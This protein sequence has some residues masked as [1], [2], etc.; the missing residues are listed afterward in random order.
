MECLLHV[1]ECIHSQPSIYVSGNIIVPLVQVS[2]FWN[3]LRYSFKH[4]H[5]QNHTIKSVKP[6]IELQTK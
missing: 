6:W 2:D 5:G 1:K 3:V 4:Y